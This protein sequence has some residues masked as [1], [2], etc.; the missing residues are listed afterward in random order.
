MKIKSLKGSLQLTVTIL[1]LVIG[2]AIS[3][4]VSQRYSNTLI[5][6]ATSKAFNIAHKLAL[7]A[8][9]SILINDLV[10]L[11]KQLEDQILSTPS[12]AY[13]FIE[14]DSHVLAHTFTAGIPTDLI[15]I[16][17]PQENE[18]GHLTKIISDQDVRYLDVAWPIFNRQAGIL[19]LGLSEAP[20]QSQVRQLWMQM[21]LIT[22]VIVILA[23]II[24][25]FVINLLTRPLI[26]LTR[27]VELIDED[28]LETQL[29]IN[30]RHEVTKLSSA[31][32]SMLTRLKEYTAKLNSSNLQLEQKH[33]ELDRTHR[34]LRAYFVI[35]QEIAAL[36]TLYDVCTYL[37]STFKNILACQNMAFI[38]FGNRNELF[39]LTEDKIKTLNHH[40][41]EQAQNILNRLK[42][43]RFGTK[44]VFEPLNLP[45]NLQSATRL[46]VFPLGDQE[47]PL[48]ALLVG[49]HKH[50]RCIEDEIEVIEPILI[51]T[52]G[53]IMRAVDLEEELRELRSR[54][55]TTA[56]FNGLIGKDA[57]MQIIYKLIED[58][59][60]TDTTVLIQGESGTGKELVARAIHSQS[61]RRNSSFVVVNCSAYPAT[62]LES[63]LFGHEKGA[64]TGATRRKPGRF[65]QADGGTVFLDEIGEISPTA[66]IKLLR[67]L[68]SRKF[69]RLGGE[70]TISVDLRI[71]AATNKDLSQEVLKGNFR[72]DLYYRLNVI[73]I[74]LPPLRKRR[75][76]ILLLAQ[77]FLRRFSNDQKKAIDEFNPEA[78]RLLFDHEWPGNVRELENAIEHAVV[79]A[80]SQTIEISDIPSV[81]SQKLIDTNSQVTNSLTKNESRLVK[82]ILEECNW[83]KTQAA[84]KLGISRSTL[85]EKLKKYEIRQ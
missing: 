24:V 55:D 45:N 37:I 82:E 78:L 69:E 20:Y 65:E 66:Q 59:A 42:S 30:G 72:E 2:L 5:D 53:A 50:C 73:P 71:L 4:F 39:M 77:Y 58:V 70:Q 61:Q 47:P 51:Q 26:K 43:Q 25:H 67:V 75:N 6:A 31:F 60:P 35:A 3:Q 64:F 7:D 23:L 1:I 33:L 21:S 52:R 83:N 16:N 29:E 18:N 9:D 27:A 38:I 48:G 84:T 10:T 44:K 34:Q 17:Q 57:Q 49:C 14:K 79:M 54:V 40:H 56:E 12:V 41:H 32:N 80:K 76:D 46:A 11:Q 22:L 28:N 19:R 15:G 85:Y 74:N 36:S 63:E 13:I 68:Q 81:V 62:L 8:A